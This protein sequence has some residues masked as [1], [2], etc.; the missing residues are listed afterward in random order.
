MYDKIIQEVRDNTPQS[1]YSETFSLVTRD[2]SGQP[3]Q[4]LAKCVF[5]KTREKQERER[6][7]NNKKRKKM[8]K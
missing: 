1:W 6:G 3:T 8:F 2:G 4:L 5:I 7:A